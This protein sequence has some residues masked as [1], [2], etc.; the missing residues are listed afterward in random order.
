MPGI[1]E[2]N[3]AKNNDRIIQLNVLFYHY[4][5]DTLFHNKAR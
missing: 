2:S 5:K 3:K 1:I 4:E